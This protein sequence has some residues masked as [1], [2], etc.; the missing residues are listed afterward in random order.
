[1][2]VGEDRLHCVVAHRLE[3]R[4]R[5]VAFADLQCLLPWAMSFYFGRGRKNA[6]ELERQPKHLAVGKN[7]LQHTRL[8]VH[9]DFRGSWCLVARI[10]HASSIAVRA[11]A[12]AL[13]ADRYGLAS[14]DAA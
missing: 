5:H 12:S 3:P 11:R 9:I 4:D 13:P 6:Q 10:G 1:M 14:C 7:N 8:R 2:T